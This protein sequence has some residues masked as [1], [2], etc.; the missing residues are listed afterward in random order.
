VNLYTGEDLPD[1]PDQQQ[2]LQRLMAFAEEGL[3]THAS[4]SPMLLALVRKLLAGLASVEKFPV[5]YSQLMPAPSSL[6]PFGG[7]SPGSALLVVFPFCGRFTMDGVSCC[8][9]LN[10]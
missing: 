5:Q 4:G 10:G 9:N 7:L 1:K 8:L 2:L 6:R 3:T